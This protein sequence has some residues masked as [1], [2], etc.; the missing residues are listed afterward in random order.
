MASVKIERLNHIYQQEISMILMKEVKNQDIKFVTIT[1]VEITNDLSFC[2]V[3]YTVFDEE[4]KDKVRDA[5]KKTSSFIRSRLAEKVNLR[6]TPELIF[7][8]DN[9]ISYGN[10]IEKI[11]EEIHK[12]ENC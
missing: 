11:I 7:V 12:S 6:H 4:K 5:L 2:K 3:F 1:G 10:H 9:S 8:Y